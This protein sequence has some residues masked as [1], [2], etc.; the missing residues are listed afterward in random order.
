MDG[1]SRN[2][3]DQ[4]HAHLSNALLACSRCIA[5]GGIPERDLMEV[6]KLL[7][8]AQAKLYQCRTNPKDG[9]SFALV[10]KF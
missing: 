3:V 5:S 6:A 1:G 4:L 9:E 10:D 8:A 2:E 7:T